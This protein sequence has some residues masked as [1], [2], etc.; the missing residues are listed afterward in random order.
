MSSVD[1]L[2]LAGDDEED[3]LVE[4]LLG[5]VDEL[6]LDDDDED[7]C[8]LGAERCMVPMWLLPMPPQSFLS[9]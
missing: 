9:C 4:E 1:E 5:A 8:I 7:S 3:V 6:E 2:A